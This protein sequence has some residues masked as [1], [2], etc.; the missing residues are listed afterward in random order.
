MDNSN[1]MILALENIK[2]SIEEE[3]YSMATEKLDFL[4]DMIKDQKSTKE[5]HNG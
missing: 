2:N 5:A 1:F 4:I 3:R